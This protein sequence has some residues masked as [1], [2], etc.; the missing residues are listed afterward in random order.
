M[1]SQPSLVDHGTPLPIFWTPHRLYL[2]RAIEWVS[3]YGGE[4]WG[5]GSGAKWVPV[6]RRSTHRGSTRSQHWPKR[7]AKST[8]GEKPENWMGQQRQNGGT[9]KELGG[10]WESEE[11]TQR[12]RDLAP[13]DPPIHPNH[14]NYG[15][16]HHQTPPSAT[17]H[18]RPPPSTAHPTMQGPSQ[19]SPIP[20]PSDTDLIV[21]PPT[22]PHATSTMYPTL[23]RPAKSTYSTIQNPNTTV[24]STVRRTD[25]IVQ[26]YYY[27]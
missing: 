22:L 9:R 12:D 16:I 13:I 17:A 11:R 8:N 2:S 20:S 4:R 24:Y 7:G 25:S 26:Y 1:S 3:S 21:R 15:L 10:I 18:R 14:P 27:Y 19:P 5:P 23:I 6:R